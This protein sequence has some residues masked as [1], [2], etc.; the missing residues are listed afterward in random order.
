MQ[1]LRANGAK[2]TTVKRIED[3]VL[4][5]EEKLK[6]KLNTPMDPG[7]TFEMTGMDYLVVDELHDYKNLA[8]DTN[9]ESAAIE[10]SQRAQKLHMVVEYLRDK[11]N[12]RAITGATATPIANSI[13]EAYVMQRYLRPDLLEAA[14]I[15]NF[16]DWAATFGKTKTQLEMSVDGNSWALKTRFAGFRNIQ[17][18]QRMF[19][20]AADVK[21][22]EDLNLPVP[23]LARRPGDGARAPEIISV[24]ATEAQIDYVQHLGQRAQR[25]KSRQVDPREDNMLSIS[26][27]GRAAA[28]DLRLLLSRHVDPDDGLFDTETGA[29]IDDPEQY[30]LKIG[31][32]ADWMHQKWAESKD[33]VYLDRSGEPHPRRGGLVSA[34]CDLGTPSENWNAY[35]A[36]KQRLVAH[37]GVDPDLI[38]YIHDAKNDRAKAR[39]FAQAK[40]GTIQFLLG[41]T[42]KMGVGTNVQAR[43]VAMLHV[44]CPWR[45]ADIEQRDGRGVRQG[46]QNA[47]IAIARVVTEGTFD[48]RMWATQ[49]RKATFINQFMKGNLDVREVDDIG[50]AALSA[51]EALAIASGNPLVLEKAELDVEVTKLDRLRRALQRSQSMLQVRIREAE[52]TIPRLEEAIVDFTA[53]IAKRQPTRGDS[54]TATIGGRW[55][56]NR[57]EAGDLLAARLRKL[58]EDPRSVWK[59]FEDNNIG[60]LGGFT[61][62]AC[63]IPT[64]RDEKVAVKFAEIGDQHHVSL[65]RATLD[66]GGAAVMIRLE[67]GLEGLDKRLEFATNQLATERDELARATARLG[68]PFEHTERLV[69]LKARQKE[70][71]TELLGTHKEADGQ[72]DGGGDGEAAT[73][74]SL[75]D[76]AMHDAAAMVNM[77]GGAAMVIGPAGP[78]VITRDTGRGP[79][80]R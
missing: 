9:I 24:P 2:N 40:D 25:V 68:K 17:E 61:L 79:R 80:Q 74:P 73:E 56:D 7:I 76:L 42:S 31:A 1:Q 65:D 22:P 45:P 19:H 28:L 43:M 71:N 20:V 4:K 78:M 49:A 27:D 18:L 69:A 30:G 52:G 38:A 11:H 39:L 72:P 53:A 60:K 34:F 26:S 32:A 55:L 16:D 12:G 36:I 47:E 14:G 41:S 66:K 62:N 77:A 63:N 35:D 6:A 8:T 54:F 75:N 10:G 51:N 15:G 67:N 58:L 46:N 5:A 21:L 50:D 70:I 57:V 13:T 59:D 23:K 3:A 64:G 29:V 33:H 37:H 48:A 44:D